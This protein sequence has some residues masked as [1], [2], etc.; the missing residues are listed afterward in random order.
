MQIVRL[1]THPRRYPT[2][3]SYVNGFS[4]GIGL[5]MLGLL[6]PLY[7]IHLGM[8]LSSQGVIIAAPAIFMIL[9]RLPGGAICDRFGERVV[10]W[11]SFISLIACALVA[12]PSAS[13]GPLIVA[14]LF[15]GASRSVYWTAGQSYTSRSAEGQAGKTMGRLL[16]LQSTGGIVGGVVGGALSQVFGFQVAFSAAAAINCVGLISTVLLPP[17]ARKDQVRTI[18]GSFAPAWPMF[19]RRNLAL[20]HFTAFTSAA[21]ASLVGGLFLAFFKEV[22]YLNGY[23]GT[24]RSLNNVGVAVIAFPF[25]VLLAQFGARNLAVL[26]MTATGLLSIAIALTGG[27]PFAPVVLM[28][29]SGMTFGL[30]RTLYTALA[31]QNSQPHQ[32]AMALAVVSLYWA[33]AMLVVPLVFGYIAESLSI[34]TALYI[35][36]AFSVAMG[37]LA[38]LFHA[39]ARSASP[40]EAS[41]PARATESS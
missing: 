27:V 23:V 18:W 1:V 19:L 22:G 35:F 38:P 9:L 39:I 36:G 33:V 2:T 12:L 8:S 5:N 34:R 13:I 14:Q 10:L 4:Y 30:L 41:T 25:G 20:A 32:R 6:V 24:L 37:L 40:S 21:Y 11:F 26:G 15:A 17:L 28:T 29:A 3:F 7:A 31:A 16:S